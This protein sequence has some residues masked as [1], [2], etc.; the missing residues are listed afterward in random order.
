MIYT[1]SGKENS[2]FGQS[3]IIDESWQRKQETIR[4]IFTSALTPSLRIFSVR[5]FYCGSNSRNFS[6]KFI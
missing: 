1:S 4:N 2:S 6:K 5:T 3:I